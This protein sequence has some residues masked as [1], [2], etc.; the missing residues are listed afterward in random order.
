[1]G[2]EPAWTALSLPAE[3]G[4]FL[5]RRASLQHHP[6]AESVKVEQGLS[7]RALYGTATLAL[8]GDVSGPG[9]LYGSAKGPKYCTAA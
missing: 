5:S 7:R 6:P 2:V 1:M 9:T 8:Y 4:L 3:S